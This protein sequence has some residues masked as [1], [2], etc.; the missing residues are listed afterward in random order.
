MVGA[1]SCSA[2]LHDAAVDRECLSRG[3]IMRGSGADLSDMQADFAVYSLIAAIGGARVSA[4][5]RP[6]LEWSNRSA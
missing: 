2:V 4:R 1:A 3:S 5:T 6:G